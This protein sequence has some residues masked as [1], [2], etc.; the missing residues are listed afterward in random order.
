MI[1]NY[2]KWNKLK[3]L[4]NARLLRPKNIKEGQVWWCMI[5]L[6]IGSEVDGKGEQY[7]RL[8]L[9]LKKH[10]ESTFLGLPLTS[11]IKS[12][13]PYLFTMPEHYR[14]GTALFSQAKT[15]DAARLVHKKTEIDRKLLEQIKAAYR[16]Y[17]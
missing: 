3:F 14:L 4:T 10:G 8:V 15:L 17:L 16:E 12:P 11:K 13:K 5:G 7:V 2:T 9:I 1:K 6:N